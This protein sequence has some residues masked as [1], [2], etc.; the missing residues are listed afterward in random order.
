MSTVLTTSNRA[1]EEG[2]KRGRGK[3]KVP[4]SGAER[5]DQGTSTPRLGAAKNQR[6][7]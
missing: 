1:E 6:P 2:G 3:P 4:P 5:R 7:Y